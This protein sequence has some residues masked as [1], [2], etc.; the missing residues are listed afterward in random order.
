MTLRA[1]VGSLRMSD[2]AASHKFYQRAALGAVRCYLELHDSPKVEVEDAEPDYASMS[3]AERKKAKAKARKAKAAAEKKAA[4]EEAE[5]VAKREA[6][7][8][9]RRKEKEGDEKGSDE[10]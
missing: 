1:Y 3:A 5:A 7:A 6:K 9:A 4:E 2:G 10:K 8:A